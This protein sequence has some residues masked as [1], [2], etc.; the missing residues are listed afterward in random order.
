MTTEEE[1]ELLMKLLKQYEDKCDEIKK[2]LRVL[3]K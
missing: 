1:I 3:V 2:R